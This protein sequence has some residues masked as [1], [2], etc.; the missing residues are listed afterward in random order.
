VSSEEEDSEGEGGEA[1]PVE[2]LEATFMIFVTGDVTVGYGRRFNRSPSL[3][4]MM[5]SRGSCD[6]LSALDEVSSEEEAG[7][8]V[9]SKEEEGT[10]RLSL[11]LT[12]GAVQVEFI[13]T[14]SLKAPGFNRWNL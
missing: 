6:F 5:N 12:V 2:W 3:T 4:V 11:T 8:A 1:V 9:L 7:N 14:H 10:M 13:F